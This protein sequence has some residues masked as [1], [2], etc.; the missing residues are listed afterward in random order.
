MNQGVVDV[1]P[2]EFGEENHFDAVGL[3]LGDGVAKLLP[4]AQARI[5]LLGGVAA[6]L[7][8]AVPADQL[9][10]GNAVAGAFQAVIKEV[11]VGDGGYPAPAN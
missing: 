3:D 9:N 5:G 8:A 1:G 7:P 4:G 6:V 11:G 2:I 10:G